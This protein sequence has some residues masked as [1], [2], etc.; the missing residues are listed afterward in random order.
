L[1]ARRI[2]ENGRRLVCADA[3]TDLE[4]TVQV[5]IRAADVLP[6]YRRY[7]RMKLDAIRR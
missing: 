4:F 5:K 6:W 7:A 2:V 3:K 1:L